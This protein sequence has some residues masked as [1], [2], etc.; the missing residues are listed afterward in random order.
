MGG[1]PRA[2]R[3]TSRAYGDSKDARGT[4][5]LR[6]QSKR[7]HPPVARQLLANYKGHYGAYAINL[8]VLDL[9]RGHVPLHAVELGS[10]ETG[11]VMN[12]ELPDGRPL[13]V[14][15]TFQDEIAVILSFHVSIH[16]SGG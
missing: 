6:G 9:L 10:G 12:A 2:N 7:I 5:S 11:C 16:S 1:V 14:K 4:R 8:F 3:L 15:L 13:Y